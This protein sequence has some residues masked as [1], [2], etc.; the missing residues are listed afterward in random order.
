[1][2]KLFN[3]SGI[4]FVKYHKTNSKGIVISSEYNGERLY[5]TYMFLFDRNGNKYRKR[6]YI[7]TPADNF[8]IISPFDI[9]FIIKHYRLDRCNFYIDPII[10]NYINRNL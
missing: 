4:I 10:E 9:S 8:D 6:M 2:F 5:Y 3:M 1:M 7:T